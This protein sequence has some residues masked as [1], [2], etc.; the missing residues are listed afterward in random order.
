MASAYSSETNSQES[1]IMWEHGETFT[2]IQP[3]SSQSEIDPPLSSPLLSP[4]SSQPLTPGLTS[5][6]VTMSVASPSPVFSPSRKV[7]LY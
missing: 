4:T 2:D 1:N 6:M 3:P 5:S 7:H